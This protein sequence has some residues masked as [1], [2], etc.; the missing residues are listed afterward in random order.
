VIIIS[1]PTGSGK[2]TLL[3]T[4]LCALDRVGKNIITLEDPIEYSIRGLTQVQVTPKLS[5]A[6]ALRSILRDC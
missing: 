5:F 2:T 3:Y 6:K 4:L 1:G